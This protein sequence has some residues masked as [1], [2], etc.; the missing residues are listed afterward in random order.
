MSSNTFEPLVP[1]FILKCVETQGFK[2]TGRL[3]PLSSYENRVYQ[4]EVGPNDFI[5]AKFYRPDRWDLETVLAEYTFLDR[6][7]E[8][9]FPIIL[10]LELRHTIPESPYLAKSSPFTYAFYEKMPGQHHAELSPDERKSLGRWIAILHRLGDQLSGIKRPPL[11]EVEKHIKNILSQPFLEKDLRQNLEVTLEMTMSLIGDR[12][13]KMHLILTHGDLHPGN[14]LWHHDQ[15]CFLDFDDCSMAPAI[16]D[17]WML[18][19]GSDD[20]RKKQREILISSYETIRPFPHEE[21]DMVEP[22]RTYR[23]IK[24]ASWIGE[25]YNEPVFKQ[26]FPYYKERRFWDEFTLSLKEQISLMQG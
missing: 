5:I 4:V 2:P 6:L 17:L 23:I 21:W 16:Q 25:R 10:P 3:Y 22:L 26:T 18:T 24:H 12:L 7:Y 1:D 19:Y 9:E 11:F 13:Q 20:E 14:I 15:P 8:L